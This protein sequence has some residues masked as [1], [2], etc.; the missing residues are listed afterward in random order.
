[1]KVLAVNVQRLIDFLSTRTDNRDTEAFLSDW[2]RDGVAWTEV[3]Q[4]LEVPKRPGL[5]LWF[6]D[7]DIDGNDRIVPR[8]VGAGGIRLK[9]DGTIFQR[10]ARYLPTDR[11]RRVECNTRELLH[12]RGTQ[13]ELACHY[14]EEILGL[15]AHPTNARYCDSMIAM[16]ERGVQ[17]VPDQ[18][19]GKDARRRGAV[20]W[21]LHGGTRL[22]HMHVTLIEA[23]PPQ[24]PQLATWEKE[25]QLRLSRRNKHQLPPLPP[26][27]DA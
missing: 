6:S 12:G 25:L 5:Y 26:T 19:R 18:G 22:L 20:D 13:C 17:V 9:Q 4:K 1:M 16:I 3:H 8:K 24:Q 10:M 15:L 7:S 2:V 27:Y 11:G 23:A 14:R 21:A